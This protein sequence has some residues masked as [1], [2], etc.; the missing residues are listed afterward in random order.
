MTAYSIW[1]SL[2]SH[3]IKSCVHICPQ[4]ALMWHWPDHQSRDSSNHR[5]LLG[6]KVVPGLSSRGLWSSIGSSWHCQQLQ[7]TTLPSLPSQ[8]ESYGFGIEAETQHLSRSPMEC[9]C[10]ADRCC[11][12]SVMCQWHWQEKQWGKE[13]SQQEECPVASNLSWPSPCLYCSP[14]G[15]VTVVHAVQ[16]GLSRTRRVVPLHGLLWPICSVRSGRHKMNPRRQTYTTAKDNSEVGNLRK[17]GRVRLGGTNKH[18]RGQCVE[19]ADNECHAWK[20]TPKAYM[21]RVWL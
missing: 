13:W 12:P 1:N 18:L 8:Y 14:P 21:Y 20:S 15:P 5:L 19:H 3:F 7:L 2:L 4:L 9:L 17:H 10:V 6:S 11:W 16:V